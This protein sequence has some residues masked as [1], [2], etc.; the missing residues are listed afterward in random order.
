M[1]LTKGFIETLFRNYMEFLLD[2]AGKGF[3]LEKIMEQTEQLED[4]RISDGRYFYNPYEFALVGG[5]DADIREVHYGEFTSYGILRNII[6]Y[7][8]HGGLVSVTFC[9]DM[10]NGEVIRNITMHELLDNWSVFSALEEN[11]KI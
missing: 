4:V 8:E 5:R 2:I 6:C 9:V 10:E 3:C 7:V 11:P 1:K